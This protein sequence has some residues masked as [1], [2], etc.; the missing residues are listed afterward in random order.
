MR[1][2]WTGLACCLAA[3][4][5]GSSV[6]GQES[7]VTPV[8][9][10][11]APVAAAADTL[12]TGDTVWVMLS[13]ALVMLMTPGLAFFYG[14]LVRKKNV[15]S[16]LMQCFMVMCLISVQWV[17][18][19][20]SLAFGPDLGGFIGKLDWA[21]FKGVDFAPSVYSDRIPHSA[22]AIYQMMFAVITPGLILGAFAERL[23]FGAFCL[24]SLL[25]A[26]L[27][28][29]PVCHWIWGQGGFLGLMGG[30]GAIDFAGGI[31]V[32]V[33]AG[34]A[35]LAAAVYLGRRQGYPHIMSPPHNL[36]LAVL[37][38]GLLWFGWF[39]FNAGSALAMN[40]VAVNAFLCTH[41]AG[42]VAGLTWCVLDWFKFGR[43]TTLGM[44][45]GAVAGLAAVTP[46]A[47][48]VDLGGA[49][50]IGI[51]SSIICW[52]A[53]TSLKVW[54]KYDDSLD[55]FG[56]HGVGGIWGSL[57]AGIWATK[58]VNPN[59]V[60]GL[61]AGHGVQ[62]LIQLK[63]IGLCMVYS[64]VVSWILLKFV[65]MIATLRA[66]PYEEQ[67]GLDLTQHREAGYTVID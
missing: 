23:R 16:I 49:C 29:D 60:D 37:G 48:F 65:D 67:V 51:I 17:V 26:T 24:F 39:G 56:V 33:N 18:L 47:G 58:A 32:H 66:T 14:G 54:L 21:W 41:L 63:A 45:T 62:V 53:V 7:V 28:Y 57:A 15:L 10:A 50:W 8:E 42:A 59:G 44:I 22:F 43:P 6:F 25:W 27:V 3:W 31:V 1:K 55:A 38:A 36:P 20:Y 35:A 19:G 11:P 34:M 5:M 9:A 30:A 4:V 13:A 52:M 2:A 64:F 40:G 61:L 12:N 46:G